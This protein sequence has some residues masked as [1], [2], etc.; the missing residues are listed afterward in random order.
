[1]I[2]T[3]TVRI[4]YCQALLRSGNVYAAGFVHIRV[5]IPRVIREA[6]LELNVD[7]WVLCD[8]IE[9]QFS[10]KVKSKRFELACVDET[11]INKKL[12][13]VE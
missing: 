10:T 2:W 8:V 4:V 12:M 6:S 3:F 9:R 5:V 13:R 11:L 1:V 7:C